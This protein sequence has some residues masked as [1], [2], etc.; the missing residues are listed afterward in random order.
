MRLSM[1]SLMPAF[2]GC[3][4]T[5]HIPVDL[6]LDVDATLP[7]GAAQVRICIED[8]VERTFGA[9]SGRYA[10]TGLFADRVSDVTIDVLDADAAVIA[11]AGPVEVDS[12]YT[13]AD[14]QPCDGEC[15]DCAG[16]G[17]LPAVGEPSWTLGVRFL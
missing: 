7:E 14:L 5:E 11:Q 13:I 3:A 17:D 6:E 4:R 12:D 9:A 8:G 2:C 10:V 15:I 1:I 16:T